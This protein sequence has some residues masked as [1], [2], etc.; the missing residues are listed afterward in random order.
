MAWAKAD[1]DPTMDWMIERR[2]AARLV[3]ALEAARSVYL[4]LTC[5]NDPM[6]VDE[7]IERLGKALS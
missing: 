7:R 5:A 2:D 3:E 4:G 1:R 6:D